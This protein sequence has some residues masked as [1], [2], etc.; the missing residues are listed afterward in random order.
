M[1]KSCKRISLDE[2]PSTQTWAKNHYLELDPCC[3]SCIWTKNQ[4]EGKGRGLKKWVSSPNKDLTCTFYFFLSNPPLHATQTLSL[5]GSLILCLIL[6]KLSFHPQ[7]RWPNDLLLNKKK[8]AGIL[9]EVEFASDGIHVFLGL[10]LNVN[11]S[12]EE[13]QTIDQKATSMQNENKKNYDLEKILSLIEQELIQQ[14]EIYEKE[15]FKKF[16]SLF[17]HRL[18]YKNCP[19]NFFDGEKTYSGIFY[20]ITSEGGLILKLENKELKTFYSGHLIPLID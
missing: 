13:I 11:A 17:E 12:S 16:L 3:I 9:T 5:F 7:I 20:S 8:V 10:G 6:E 18:A 1:K 2:I 15:G 14:L 19:I 4:T